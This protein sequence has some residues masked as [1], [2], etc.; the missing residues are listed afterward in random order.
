MIDS[1]IIDLDAL[2]LQRPYY[3]TLVLLQSYLPIS[4]SIR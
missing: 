1:L 4:V 2:L 3:R